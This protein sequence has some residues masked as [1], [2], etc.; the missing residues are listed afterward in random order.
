MISPRLAKEILAFI[1]KIFWFILGKG[2]PSLPMIRFAGF[3]TFIVFDS[4]TSPFFT[5]KTESAESPS[6]KTI[7]FLLN[8]TGLK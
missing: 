2:L 3:V 5:M 6:E 1:E 4:S 7:W 8:F